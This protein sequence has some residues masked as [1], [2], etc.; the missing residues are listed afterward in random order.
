ME[1][2]NLNFNGETSEQF[3]D[4]DR[5]RARQILDAFI[6]ISTNATIKQK[7]YKVYGTGEKEG[8]WR[9]NEAKVFAEIMAVAKTFNEQLFIIFC[10]KTIFEQVHKAIEIF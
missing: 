7:E 9:L 8:Y 10:A 2:I 6:E 4:I 3:F 5:N 1:M